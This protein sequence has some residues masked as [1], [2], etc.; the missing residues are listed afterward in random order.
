MHPKK[1]IWLKSCQKMFPGSGVN[2]CR[3][4]GVTLTKLFKFIITFLSKQFICLSGRKK[5]SQSINH[6]CGPSFSSQ[7]LQDKTLTCIQFLPN[8]TFGEDINLVC[9]KRKIPLIFFWVSIW[10]FA[11]FPQYSRYITIVSSIVEGMKY[12]F[13]DSFEIVI[14]DDA[15][16]QVSRSKYKVK[17]DNYGAKSW[18]I[19]LQI[20][21]IWWYQGF[22][23]YVT[24]K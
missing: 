19:L 10:Y 16:A 6:F 12:N 15:C 14:F 18:N 4:V 20:K 5:I 3:I 2:V 17:R 8:K 1:K 24:P 23:L 7:S 9:F 11:I 21:A 22:C 13:N